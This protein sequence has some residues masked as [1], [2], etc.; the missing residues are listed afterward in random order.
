MRDDDERLIEDENQVEQIEQHGREVFRHDWDS[1]GPGAGAGSER[2]VE[3][4][5]KFFLCSLD[6]GTRGPFESLD[7]VLDR[8]ELDRVSEASVELC[9][10]ILTSSEIAARIT[11]RER[12]PIGILLNGESWHRVANGRKFKPVVPPARGG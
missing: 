2:I 7:E 8:F 10:P 9:S 5:G 6:D 1:G 11:C 3:F 12:G 4:E